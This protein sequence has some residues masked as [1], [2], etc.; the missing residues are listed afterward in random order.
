M[1]DTLEIT[2]L[3]GLQILVGGEPVTGFYSRK[4]EALLVYLAC[5]GRPQSRDVLADLLWDDVTQSRA[6]GNLRVVLHNLREK[7]GPY[8]EITRT[9]VALNLG[10]DPS[11]GSGQGVW[12]DVAELEDGLASPAAEQV[13]DAL[14]LYQGD[15]LAGFYVRDCPRFE[16]WQLVEQERIRGA[17]MGALDGLV[18]HYLERGDVRPGAG[19][20]AQAAGTGPA[21]GASTPASDALPGPPGTTQRRSGALRGLS[22]DS[23]RGAGGGTGTGDCGAVRSDPGRGGDGIRG[24]AAAAAQ[25]A[26]ASDALYRAG[27]RVGRT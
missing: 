25:S 1:N 7:L 5:T 24:A 20:R 27:E 16:E 23:G 9:T 11:T 12:F 2:T 3:G 10:D 22:S 13:A 17:V 14:S 19:S 26:S 6:M 21:A 15:F 8:V 4:V 18:A